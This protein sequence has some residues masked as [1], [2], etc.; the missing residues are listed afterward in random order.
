MQIRKANI[1]D[2]TDV[3][4]VHAET[5]VS[6]YRRLFSDEY[7]EQQTL[8]K[9]K[10]FWMRFINEGKSV[11]V[12]EEKSGEIVGFI[13]PRV[14]RD[15]RQKYRGEISA[16][17]VTDRFQRRGVGRKLMATCAKLMLGNDIRSM[18]VWVLKE[19]NA[20]HFYKALGGE[21]FEA[22]IERLDNKDFVKLGYRWDDLQTLAQLADVPLEC[23]EVMVFDEE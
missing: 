15:D 8:D 4:R 10:K 6:T 18:V 11:Y 1:Y 17:Y 14:A 12:V 16:L 13:V 9:R 21:E 2:T 5:W 22:R 3:A 20:C 7:V 23:P 19:M